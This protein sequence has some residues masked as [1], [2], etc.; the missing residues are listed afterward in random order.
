MSSFAN[1]KFIEGAD[2]DIREQFMEVCAFYVI[3]KKRI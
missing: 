2:T 3:S 1:R